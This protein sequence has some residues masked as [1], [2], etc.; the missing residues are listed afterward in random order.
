MRWARRLTLVAVWL[1]SN[2]LAQGGITVPL[3]SA[4]A[5]FPSA[6]RPSAGVPG[7]KGNGQCIVPAVRG[8]VADLSRQPRLLPQRER[9]GKR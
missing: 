4:A 1:A 2:H 3:I 9:E 5:P 6:A 8:P 7:A